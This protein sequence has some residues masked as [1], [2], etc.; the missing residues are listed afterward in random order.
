MPAM[1]PAELW[2]ESGRWDALR[3][4]AHAPEG[5]PRPRLLPRPDPRGDR[6]VARA[7]RGPQLPRAAAVALPDP[8]EVP[9][10][11]ASA[12]R[13]APRPRVHHEGR[14]LLPRHAGVAAGAL[15]RDGRRVRAHLRAS[16]PGLPPGRGRLGPDRRQG[17]HRVHGA[18][19]ER[20]GRA[21]L[22]RA[23]AGPPTSRPPTTVVPRT[24]SVTEPRP[25]EKVHTP[26]IRTIAELAGVPRHP[27]ARH[28][29]DD[30]RCEDRPTASARVLLRPRR[31]RA[32]PRQGRRGP[33][34]GVELLEEEE[35]ATFGIPKGSLGPVGAAGR[36][37]LVIADRVARRR[38]RVGR[39]RQR[40]RLPP[41][42]RAARPRLR[43]RRSGPTSSSRRP[44]DGC[45][46]C[47]GTLAGRA[48][49]RGQPGL[50]AR[51]ASTPSRWA[52]PS[53]TRTA[54]SSRSS[55]A[56]TAWA[57]RARSPPSSSSTTT[58][59][60]S[61]GRSS[62]AP[63][64][65]AVLP[66]MAEGEV[67]EVAERLWRELADGRRRGRHRRPR[68]A[69][70]RE[71]RRRRPH[72][73][74]VPGRRRQEGPRRGRRR[75]QG[76]RDGRARARCRSP[77][78]S[79]TVAALVAERARASSRTSALDGGPLAG[80]VA[81]RRRRRVLAASLCPASACVESPGA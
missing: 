54:T 8:G 67:A 27:R 39:R 46:E 1:Q 80:R 43:G 52:R 4:R 22:L 45:P 31:P 34:P 76:P 15:R 18:R 49:H 51:H 73:L 61:S 48:R 78:P 62:V 77:R 33:Y 13:A 55:W 21:R 24:P 58:R 56:A 79:T 2:Q 44:G 9:R 35:F 71:V 32:Q 11:G 59:T 19:R 28:R 5:P 40:G 10:R 53:P 38:R 63:L 36:A 74:A 20:R 65:V 75:A 6:H 47:G 29:Q 16:R 26:D 42:R 68:R 14:L 23:A 66:L 25:M 41:H 70:R 69:R 81:T 3:P 50:P 12:L 57:C 64:E 7:R 60:A 30:G 72:R 17:H 37:R